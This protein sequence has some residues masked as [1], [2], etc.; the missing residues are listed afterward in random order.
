[1]SSARYEYEITADVAQFRRAMDQVAND[2]RLAGS[3]LRNAFAGAVAG[4]SITGAGAW[5]VG[6]TK[7]AI[8]VADNIGKMSQRVGVSVEALSELSYAGKLADV[9]TEQLGEGLKK[10][11]VNLQAAAGGSKEYREAFSRVGIVTADLANLRAD[12]ALARIADAFS[13]AADG[14]GKTALAVQLFG[15]SGSDLIP[16]LNQGAAGLKNAADEA[17]RLGLVISTDSA[18]AAETFNDNLTRLKESSSSFGIALSNEVLPS[19]T[20]FTN[21]LLDGQKAFGTFGSALFLLGTVNPF[22]TLAENMADSRRE[23]ERLKSVLDGIPASGGRLRES[24]AGQLDSEKRRLEFFKAQ[25]L[26]QIETGNPG[27]FDAR[28]L[29][30]RRRPA[31]LTATDQAAQERAEREAARLARAMETGTQRQAERGANTILDQFAQIA[32]AR[33]EISKEL[34]KAL[35]EGPEIAAKQAEALKQQLD[36]ILGETRGGQSAEIAKQFDLVAGALDRGKITAVQ[37]AEAY[38]LLREKEDELFAGKPDEK[39]DKLAD[40]GKESMREL[41]D[42]VKGFSRQA[43]NE[44]AQMVVDGEADF[45]RLGKSFARMVLAQQIDQNVFGPLSQSIGAGLGRLFSGAGAG[46]STATGNPASFGPQLAQYYGYRAEGGDVFGG[47]TGGWFT[48][49]ERGP[50]R[51][52]V[53]PGG[54]GTVVPNGGGS[55]TIN[56]YNDART[57]IASIAAIQQHTIRQVTDLLAM[58]NRR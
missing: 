38:D 58:Q 24:I 1:M 55:V 53:P 9:S 34:E 40:A 33:E 57:D 54:T 30:G 43:S 29:A 25:Q 15:K 52:Y 2:S 46:T 56:N 11:G 14:S 41:I 22:K 45:R 18:R 51:L 42:A 12:E 3:A 16:L 37:F 27:T 28:D 48:V 49:G 5:L 39:F 31:S 10:L 13:K 4:F 36:G 19:L 26:R 8:D 44:F 47:M 32:K 23:I 6:L 21:E 7:T 20:E 17:R 50:E 35:Q